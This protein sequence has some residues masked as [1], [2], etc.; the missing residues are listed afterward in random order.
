[1]VP[2]PDNSSGRCE[3][4]VT[5]RSSKSPDRGGGAQ[6]H[7]VRQ[8]ERHEARRGQ[9]WGRHDDDAVATISQVEARHHPF[10]PF[11][12]RPDSRP[13]PRSHGPLPRVGEEVA[14]SDPVVIISGMTWVDVRRHTEDDVVLDR[15]EPAHEHSDMMITCP[16]SGT[17][18]R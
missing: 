11:E 1:M 14:Q 10:E 18:V 6:S 12:E 5:A 17:V 16:W 8:G 4:L 7:V 2:G 15:L 3:C 13:I 9:M